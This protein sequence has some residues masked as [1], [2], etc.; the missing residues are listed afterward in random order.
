MKKGPNE[1]CQ[2]EVSVCERQKKTTSDE[3]TGSE[4]VEPT[5]LFEGLQREKSVVELSV[6]KS[7][8]LSEL[9]NKLTQTLFMSTI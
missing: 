4:T 5:N 6:E 7:C 8:S 1:S 9:G 2:T 3:S